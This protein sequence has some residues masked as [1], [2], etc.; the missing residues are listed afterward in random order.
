MTGIGMA[1]TISNWIT[2][3]SNCQIPVLH[4]S[5]LKLQQLKHN[6]QDITVT[7]LAKIAKQDP[8]FSMAILRHAC[9]SKKRE[10]TTL[11]HAISL[12]SIPFVLT[13]LN[14]LPTLEETLDKKT[15]SKI[16]N[17]YSRQYLV[18]FMSREWSV[19]RKE[20]ENE[21]IFTAALNRGFVRYI[22]YLIEADKAASLEEI[23]LTPDKD[24]KKKEAELLGNNV[25][26]IAQAVAEHWNLPELIRENYSGK[27]HNPK[28]TGIRLA[29]EL[30]R[31]IHSH[32]SIQY[33]DELI[34]RIA[35]YIR[36]PVEQ[37]PGKINS[38]IM[39]AVRNSDKHI[40]CHSIVNMMMSY[41]LPIKKEKPKVLPKINNAP[42]NTVYADC[43]TL[44]RSKSSDKS[45]RELIEITIKALKDGVGFSRVIF[46]RFDNKEK[47][48]EVKIFSQENNLP[49][50]KQLKISLALNKLFSQLLKKEQTLCIN[51]KNQ[52]RYS[53]LLPEKLRP[54]K[55]SA[56]IIT[57][58]FYINGNI[59]GCFFA[60]HGHS[61]KPL[62]KNNLNSFNTICTEL[63]R[64]IELAIEKKKPIKKVA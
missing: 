30:F 32:T 55:P 15:S 23:Y 24:H 45:T 38:I 48:L 16:L 26:E 9:R 35:D 27:H 22:L 11:S 13:M 47:C 14:D 41:P 34:H 6:K 54:L 28:I 39:N 57:N 21:E 7:V 52:H 8:G 60:D 63:K 62:T 31:Q 4:V 18:A 51:S 58:S 49:N 19:L 59:T 25:D 33:P 50:I 29:A 42:G 46:M 3:F 1:T 40:A 44:L 37:T 53:H 43:L 64:A 56:T 20:S 10:I 5:K 17:E 12:I 36:T 61:D 2:L